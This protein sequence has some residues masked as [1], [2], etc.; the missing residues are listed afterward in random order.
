MFIRKPRQYRMLAI[1]PV[2][3]VKN[4]AR[5]SH[6]GSQGLAS[7]GARTMPRQNLLSAMAVKVIKWPAPGR[8]QMDVT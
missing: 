1:K 4:L 5:G 7:L 3:L 8:L 6:S 2:L